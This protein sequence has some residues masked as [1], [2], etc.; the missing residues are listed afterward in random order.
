VVRLRLW[1]SDRSLAG[2]FVNS[3]RSKRSAG[4]FKGE[5]RRSFAG[6]SSGRGRGS[7]SVADGKKGKGARWSLWRERR[8]TLVGKVAPDRPATELEY[9][10]LLWT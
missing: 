9:L 2:R 5:S 6:K 10:C 3:P 4:G 1:A 7:I 8:H